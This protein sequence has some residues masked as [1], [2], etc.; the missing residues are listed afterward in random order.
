M[1]LTHIH[2]TYCIVGNILN[3][4][5]RACAAGVKQMP[6]CV[7]VCVCLQENIEKY[8]K[9]GRKGV[10]RCHSQWKTISIIILGRFCT[11]YK[12]RRFFTPL[13]QLLHIIG[14]V[15]PPPSKSH[16][17]VMVSNATHTPKCENTGGIDLAM[18]REA[19]RVSIPWIH[20]SWIWWVGSGIPNTFCR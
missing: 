18:Y 11:W 15:A 16:M 12:S 4:P 19:R 10:Y 8:F 3:H 14:F 7:C 6:L 1:P 2:T 13:F 17:V 5:M 9:Q 20:S